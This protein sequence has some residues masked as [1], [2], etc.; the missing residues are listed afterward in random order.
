[1][2]ELEPGNTPELRVT[3][4]AA[5][6]QFVWGE[7]V[8]E[9]DLAVTAHVERRN[10]HGDTRAAES[11][12]LRRAHVR[13]GTSAGSGWEVNAPE[14]TIGYA[15]TDDSTRLAAELNLAALQTG[16][17]IGSTSFAADLEVRLALERIASAER[18]ARGVASLRISHGELRSGSERVSDWSGNVRLDALSGSARENLDFSAGYSAHLRDARPGLAVLTAQGELPG[19]IAGLFPL[20]NLELAR[21]VTRRCRVTDFKLEHVSGGPLVSRGRLLSVPNGFY[22]TLLLRLN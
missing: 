19:W 14:L 3:A 17:R 11:L 1:H 4:Q 13:N 7:F 6:S 15:L 12:V 9:G 22:G 20:E 21:T 16:G 2:A 8:A 10:V 18:A 5:R